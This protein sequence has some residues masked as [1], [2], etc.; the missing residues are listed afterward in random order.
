MVLRVYVG[1]ELRIPTIGIFKQFLFV[2]S[3]HTRDSV[4]DEAQARL[5]NIGDVLKLNHTIENGT[6]I[7][8]GVL[9]T[10]DTKQ[11]RNFLYFSV[12]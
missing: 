9:K 10:T 6:E 11:F 7:H 8:C 1:I 2:G 3:E 12:I 5:Q 4:H